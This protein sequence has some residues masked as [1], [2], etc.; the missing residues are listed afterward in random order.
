[1]YVRFVLLFLL[2]FYF[3]LNLNINMQ[4]VKYFLTDYTLWTFTII[5]TIISPQGA[6]NYKGCI[7]IYISV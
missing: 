5:S 7:I 3:V 6:F 4:I 1:M 2:F